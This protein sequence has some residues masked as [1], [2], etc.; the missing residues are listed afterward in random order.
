MELRR[1]TQRY[2]RC[3]RVATLRTPNAQQSR[4][5]SIVFA[6]RLRSASGAPP[7]AAHGSREGRWRVGY[8]PIAWRRPTRRSAC[9]AALDCG[10]ALCRKCLPRNVLE[11]SRED[12]A[13]RRAEG[14]RGLFATARKR[15][16]KEK[17]PPPSKDNNQP[18]T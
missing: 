17:T 10:A 12:S 15:S 5:P 8:L 4:P 14:V 3:L 6:L 13:E 16:P 11:I 7:R 9:F 1:A 2:H 18:Q